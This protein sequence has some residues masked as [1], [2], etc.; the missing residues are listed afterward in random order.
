MQSLQSY[1]ICKSDTHR[2]L[3]LVFSA[4]RGI[5][6]GMTWQTSLSLMDVDSRWLPGFTRLVVRPSLLAH[7][8]RFAWI[9]W[10]DCSEILFSIKR[11][12]YD[13]SVSRM[14]KLCIYISLCSFD[15]I[16]FLVQHSIAPWC[17][18]EIESVV[19]RLQ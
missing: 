5:R 8:F 18:R 10:K 6:G 17:V 7:N 12:N 9:S 4:G 15:L 14:S 1:R 19:S 16:L 3:V 2:V 11:E 13:V